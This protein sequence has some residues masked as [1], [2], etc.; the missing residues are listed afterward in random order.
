MDRRLG[1]LPRHGRVGGRRRNAATMSV[2]QVISARLT[3]PARSASRSRDFA[4]CQNGPKKAARTRE[5][6][7]RA[8]QHL[9]PSL[10]DIL[11]STISLEDMS[12][13]RADIESR[14]G[15][16]GKIGWAK[17]DAGE[18]KVTKSPNSA[19]KVGTP[20]LFC[21]SKSLIQM[22][23]E[24]GLEPATSGVTGRRSNQ[25]SYS[26]ATRLPRWPNRRPAG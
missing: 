18:R 12:A 23:R 20:K 26:P 21:I 17:E 10:G 15:G 9:E 5:D 16:R 22:A 2:H 13:I 7:E 19:G 8:W 14:I 3:L 24:T 11:P 25:L 1:P 6:W 4:G